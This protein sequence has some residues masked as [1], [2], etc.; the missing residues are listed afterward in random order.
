M[1][2]R[3]KIFIP[4]EKDS[5]EGFQIYYQHGDCTNPNWISRLNNIRNLRKDKQITAYMVVKE[6]LSLELGIYTTQVLEHAKNPLKERLVLNPKAKPTTT[7]I[8]RKFL[9]GHPDE[10]AMIQAI[11]QQQPVNVVGDNIG[12]VAAPNHIWPEPDD[13]FP[14]PP[15]EA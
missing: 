12:M 7:I 14:P 15:L 4:E 13:V 10:G 6:L 8:K 9:L 3:Y 2:E 1:M 11:F 5:Y